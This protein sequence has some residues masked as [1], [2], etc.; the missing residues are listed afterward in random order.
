MFVASF[1]PVAA[2]NEETALAPQ[3]EGVYELP[4]HKDLLVQV[5]IHKKINRI[6]RRF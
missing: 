5:L 2:K 6:K 4:G 1:V 3:A